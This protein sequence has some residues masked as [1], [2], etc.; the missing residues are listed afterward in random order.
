M[1]DSLYGVYRKTCAQ[2]REGT[3]FW[4]QKRRCLLQSCP[5]FYVHRICDE[6]FLED[7]RLRCPSSIRAV[8]LLAY[9][10]G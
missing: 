5:Y 1:I 8:F 6:L 3:R 4:A 9:E 10:Y 7:T 2:Y